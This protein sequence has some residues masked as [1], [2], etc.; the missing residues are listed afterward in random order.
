MAPGATEKSANTQIE[1][2]ARR[3]ADAFP[4]TNKNRR[5]ALISDFH[6]RMKQ[7]GKNGVTLLAIVLLVVMISSVNVA[8]LLL[9]RA[10]CAE[11][12]WLCGWLWA[13]A[14]G[15]SCNS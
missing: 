14:A 6:F 3:M 4:A 2:I 12:K 8:N 13:Q 11:R 1:T 7:G 9:S 10:G 15:A 5:A